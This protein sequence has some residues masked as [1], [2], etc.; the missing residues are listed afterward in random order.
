[1]PEL[2]LNRD[3]DVLFVS[4]IPGMPQPD[5]IA[6]PSQVADDVIEEAAAEIGSESKKLEQDLLAGRT[7][8]F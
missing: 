1:M 4:G 8:E 6:Y 5:E 7:I 3:K 2:S